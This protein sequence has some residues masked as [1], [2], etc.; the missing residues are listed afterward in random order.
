MTV[1]SSVLAQ[2][3]ASAYRNVTERNR[4]APPVGWTQI[5]TYPTSG[6]AGLSFMRPVQSVAGV[7]V[8]AGFEGHGRLGARSAYVAIDLRPGLGRAE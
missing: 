5:A 6:V 7:G 8:P 3:A 4:I 2:L 1:D